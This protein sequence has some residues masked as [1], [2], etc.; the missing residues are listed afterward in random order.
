M[1]DGTP[2]DDRNICTASSSCQAGVCASTTVETGC[3]VAD[4]MVEFDDAQGDSGWFYG[5][6]L[7]QDT[8]YDPDTDFELGVFANGGWEPVDP[9]GSGFIYLRGFGAHPQ[10]DPVL[11]MPV[12]RWVSDVQGP[13]LVLVAVSKSDTS[14]GDGVIA[15][16]VVDGVEVMTKDVAFDD[17]DGATI[18]VQVELAI[19]TKVDALLSPRDGEAC[20]TTDYALTI[21]SAPTN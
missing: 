6:W 3:Q 8:A 19:G 7:V 10:F 16:L 2:C 4:S 14:C 13:G 1:A 5:F 15:S 17:G 12:R 20:D 18:P 21:T 9:M 11:R